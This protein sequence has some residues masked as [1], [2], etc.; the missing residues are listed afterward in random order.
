MH[1][2]LLLNLET[3]NIFLMGLKR[4]ADMI[5]FIKEK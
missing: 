3:L 5:L 1:F 4:Q 2:N